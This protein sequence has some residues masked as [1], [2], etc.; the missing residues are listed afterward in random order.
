MNNYTPPGWNPHNIGNGAMQGYAARPPQAPEDPFIPSP[1]VTEQSRAPQVPPGVTPQEPPPGAPHAAPI[2][3][4][5]YQPPSANWQSQLLSRNMIPPQDGMLGGFNRFNP[6]QPYAISSHLNNAG[7]NAG[8]MGNGGYTGMA[9]SPTGN[10]IDQQNGGGGSSK[11]G[12]STAMQ[13]PMLQQPAGS[14][15]NF[16]DRYKAA[17]YAA[18]HVAPAPAGQEQA[19]LASLR[20][21]PATSLPEQGYAISS[22]LN[23]GMFT[24]TSR[25]PRKI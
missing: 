21:R 10:W 24:P 11:T 25:F 15:G 2:N 20:T 19:L 12:Q 14:M 9:S 4:Q 22:H 8:G 5:P 13:P 1:D 17:D 6:S 16:W 23:N 3:W 7:A 18:P